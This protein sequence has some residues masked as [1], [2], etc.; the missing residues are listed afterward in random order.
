MRWN[1]SKNRKS[2]LCPTIEGKLVG[3]IGK[4][5]GGGLLLLVIVACGSEESVPARGRLIA[6]LTVASSLQASRLSAGGCVQVV[7]TPSGER[8]AEFSREVCPPAETDLLPSE[9]IAFSLS[10]VPGADLAT[11]QLKKDGITVGETS[12]LDAVEGKAL[13]YGFIKH[14]CQ[15]SDPA[16]PSRRYFSELCR[17]KFVAAG[18][19]EGRYETLEIV[20]LEELARSKVDEN[21]ALKEKELQSRDRANRYEAAQESFRREMDAARVKSEEAREALAE[22]QKGVRDSMASNLTV[23]QGLERIKAR[24]QLDV[25]RLNVRY[26]EAQLRFARA[27]QRRAQLIKERIEASERAKSRAAEIAK[28]LERYQRAGIRESDQEKTL[29]AVADQNKSFI[30]S[31]TEKVRLEEDMT[32]ALAEA[33][34]IDKLEKEELPNANNLIIEK[35]DEVSRLE[36][37]P[38]GKMD[39]KETTDK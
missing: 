33:E 39:G 31:D 10:L 35:R 17:L 38:V 34:R 29:K 24:A 12:S 8:Q 1:T 4:N 5:L 37:P 7:E 22:A 15:V 6:Y 11:W 30:L 3:R 28:Q 2:V 18:D 13:R 23:H 20:P 36:G 21:D 19:R 9:S 14:L 16:L 32:F 25:A 27:E 26:I